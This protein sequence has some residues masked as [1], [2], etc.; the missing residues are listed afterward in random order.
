VSCWRPTG[1]SAGL[2]RHES[3]GYVSSTYK[4]GQRWIAGVAYNYVESQEN[5]GAITRRSSLR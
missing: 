2:G 1:R 5:L 3:R 4:M